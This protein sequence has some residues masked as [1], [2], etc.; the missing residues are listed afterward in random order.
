LLRGRTNVL[1][2]RTICKAL[3]YDDVPDRHLYLDTG[4]TSQ[5]VTQITDRQLAP[6]GVAP[7][8]IALLTHVRD[9]EP[10]S[11]SVLARA[12][13]S[14]PTTLRDNMQRLVD[15]RLV[16]RVPN[17]RD[18]RSYLVRI[19]PRGRR[20][21]EAADPALLE[22][23]LALERHLPRPREEFERMLAELNTALAAALDDLLGAEVRSAGAA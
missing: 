10:V 15:R 1:R 8:L 17:R 12:A 6:L 22:A 18:G 21:L 9:L 20:V 14:P 16:R 4:T 11:P 13:G 2:L 7:T 3:Y 19:T 5:Y 23:Y